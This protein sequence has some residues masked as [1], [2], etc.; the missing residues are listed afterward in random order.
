MSDSCFNESAWIDRIER[1]EESVNQRLD[2]LD[3]TLRGNGGCVGYSVRID[4]I[5]RWISSQARFQK[6][7]AGGVLTALGAIVV[8]TGRAIL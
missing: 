2:R 3:E 5:E 8:E 1:F 6:W 4:R 7:I